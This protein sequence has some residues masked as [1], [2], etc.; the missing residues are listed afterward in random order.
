RQPELLEYLHHIVPELP[1]PLYLYNMPPLT[2]VAIE[3]DTVRRAMEE[4][5]IL[6]LKD[7]SGDMIYFHRLCSLLSARPDW[8]LFVGPEELLMDATIAGGTGGVPAGANLFPRLY[9]ALFDAAANGDLPRA[10]ILQA[11]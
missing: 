4:P 3:L 6:G 9:V 10:R 1:L 2:K 11:K 7:S 8:S 5:G